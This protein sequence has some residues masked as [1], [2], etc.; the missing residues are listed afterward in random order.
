MRKKGETRNKVQ[1]K[2]KPLTDNVKFREAELDVVSE[3]EM[4]FASAIASARS[5]IADMDE[6]LKQARTARLAKLK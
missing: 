2:A 5:R 6:S 1:R 3:M 4:L